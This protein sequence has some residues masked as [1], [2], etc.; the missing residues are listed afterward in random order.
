MLTRYLS[1]FW[2]PIFFS[3]VNL[4]VLLFNVGTALNVIS[5]VV[6]IVIWIVFSQKIVNQEDDNPVTADDDTNE[7]CHLVAEVVLGAQQE[8]SNIEKDTAQVGNV[9]G[10]AIVT[11]HN[12][13]TNMHEQIGFQ[14]EVV[15]NVIGNIQKA[16][17]DTEDEKNNIGYEEFALETN[18]VLKYMVDQV[19]SVS[20]DSIN[21]AHNIEDVVSEMDQVDTL[22]GDVKS[23]ADQTNLLALN[24]AIEAARAGEAGRGFAVVADEVRALSKHSNRFSDQIRDVVGNARTNIEQ[25]RDTVSK[26]ASKDMNMAIHSKENVEK[27]LKQIAGLNESVGQNLNRLNGSTDEINRNVSVAVQSLQFEDMVSQLLGHIHRQSEQ[28][29]GKFGGIANLLNNRELNA[30]SIDEVKVSLQEMK[31][32]FYNSADKNQIDRT[33]S[34]ETMDTGDVELF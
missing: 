29:S 19:V 16:G 3:A 33:V 5:T 21:M 14:G 18:K 2:I 12:S 23:I 20:Q 17:S 11:L 9:I 34:Q 25:A 8:L 30:A 24:A 32:S 15:Q 6:V 13:F 7:V 4:I 22:L 28:A 10:D 31:D 1:R 26:M 27:M